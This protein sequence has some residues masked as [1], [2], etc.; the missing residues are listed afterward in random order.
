MVYAR[1]KRKKKGEKNS[2]RWDSRLFEKHLVASKE[3]RK[4]KKKENE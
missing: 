3:E 4:R 2:V 1:K